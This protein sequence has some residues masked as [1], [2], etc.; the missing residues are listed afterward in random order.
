MLD[1]NENLNQQF[2]FHYK[3]NEPKEQSVIR[4]Q[5]KI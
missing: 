4:S 3:D 5:E 1:N 2:F